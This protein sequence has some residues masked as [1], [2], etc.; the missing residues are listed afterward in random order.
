MQRHKEMAIPGTEEITRRQRLTLLIV[1]VAGHGLK[2]MFN[3]AFFILLPEIKAGLG[4]SNTQIGTLSTFRGIAGGLANIPAGFAGDRF[5]KRRA[6]ILGGSIVLVSAFAF[7]LG[8][9]TN[10]WVA[11]IAASLFSVSITF[12][13]PAAIS[14]LSRE[15]ASRRGFAIALHGTGGSIGETLGPILVGS[16]VGII[17]WRLVLQGSVVPGLMAGLVIW[18][19]LRAIPAGKSS[20]SSIQAYVGSIAAIFRNGRL[21]L[22]LIFAA[23]FAGGQSTVLTFLPIYLD[24]DLGASSVTIGLYLS[25]AQVGGIV[26]QPLMGLASDRLGRKLILAPSLAILGLSFV[27]L[28]A[29][30]SGWIFGLVVLLMGAF[31][32]PMMSILLAA[33]MDLV[34]EGAQATTVSLVFGSAII[35]SAF[36]P[37]VA[38][39]LADSRGTEAA[40]VFGAGLVLSASFLSAVTRWHPRA[41]ASTPLE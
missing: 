22:V 29:A 10:F 15:F 9:A 30:P 27:G 7:A 4:L 21:L 16:I 41:T 2:H 8:L 6:E 24:E 5:A 39:V 33:A 14:S 19:L 38:G 20:E 13:H 35:V 26:S 3:A 37:T 25:L 11:V 28:S 40:F 23:G 18:S 12:W 34:G 31:L 32:F 17:G 36:A 1:A